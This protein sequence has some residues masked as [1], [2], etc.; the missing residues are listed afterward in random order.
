[1]R[2]TAGSLGFLLVPA[3]LALATLADNWS[4]VR[5]VAYAT[6]WLLLAAAFTYRDSTAPRV[7][8]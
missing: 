2:I 3:V 5:A 7:S 6:M 4:P 8:G 1:M